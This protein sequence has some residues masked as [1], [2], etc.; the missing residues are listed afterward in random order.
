VAQEVVAGSGSSGS[1]NAV[2][3]SASFNAPHGMSIFP[4]RT[5]ALIAGFTEHTIR[6][7]VVSTLAVSTFAGS[8]TLGGGNGVG[9]LATFNGPHD[10]AISADGSF[11][12]SVCYYGQRVR[13]IVISTGLVTTLAGSGTAGNVN[14]V[15]T[16]AG[17]QYPAGVAICNVA[18]LFVLREPFHKWEVFF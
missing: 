11:A 18:N 10:I 16:N 6:K 14:A 1:V 17:F 15:G 4:D 2:G 13:H 3:T 8:G 12:V 5:F 7:L 9:T